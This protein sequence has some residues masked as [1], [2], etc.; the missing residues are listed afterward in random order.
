MR[1]SGKV[2]IHAAFVALG[3]FVMTIF[4]LD[5]PVLIAL[6]GA[7]GMVYAASV[8]SVLASRRH[9]IAAVGAVG[10]CLA[11]AF[12]VAFLRMWGLAFNKDA[13]AL[14]SAVTRRDS[15]VYFYLAVGTGLLTLAILFV[16]AVWPAHTS[17]LA[18]RPRPKPPGRTAARTTANR[19]PAT[20][21]SPRKPSPR[22]APR[23]PAARKAGQP[24]PAPAKTAPRKQA[25]SRPR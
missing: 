4:T 6:A 11:V 1:F 7:M 9:L 22:Q 10:T 13:A 15:D 8:W 20:K 3:L 23:T 17:G 16:A 5:E 18:R 24:K 12:S 19:R 25:P 2:A 21:S 14:G